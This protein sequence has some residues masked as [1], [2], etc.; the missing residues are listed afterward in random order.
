MFSTEDDGVMITYLWPEL[1]FFLKL[2]GAQRWELDWNGALTKNSKEN[3]YWDSFASN[4]RRI[5]FI[6]MF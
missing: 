2:P 5:I 3:T 4:L 6:G 1:P